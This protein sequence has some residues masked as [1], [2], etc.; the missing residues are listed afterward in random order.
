MMLSF[1]TETVDVLRPATVKEWGQ[2]VVDWADLTEHTVEGCAIYGLSGIETV[3]GADVAS[4]LLQVFMPVGA[5]VKPTDRIR[6]RGHQ[7]D[8]VGAPI[9]QKSPLGTVSHVAVTIRYWEG[10]K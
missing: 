6:V 8:I 3:D 5:D 9:L 10:K 2:E 7:W 1:A 4:G